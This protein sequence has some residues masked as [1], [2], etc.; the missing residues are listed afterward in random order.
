MRRVV[1]FAL[2][3]GIGLG[4]ALAAPPYLRAAFAGFQAEQAADAVIDALAEARALAR[5]RGRVVRVS[6]SPGARL[7]EV[8]GGR[9]HQVPDG[10]TLSGPPTGA[11][12]RASIEFGPDGGSSGG[13]IVVA[14]RGRVWAVVVDG[15]TGDVRRITGQR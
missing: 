6:L 15:K 3:S 13:Q 11:D 14:A 9:W 5:D 2:V 1:S 4:G 8:D 12:G 7:I 10:I